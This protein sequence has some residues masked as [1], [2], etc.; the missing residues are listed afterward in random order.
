MAWADLSN[1]AQGILEY[2]VGPYSGRRNEIR[3]QFGQAPS[4]LPDRPRHLAAIVVDDGLID[5]ISRYLAA[6]TDEVYE[7]KDVSPSQIHL[8][9]AEASDLVLACRM[10]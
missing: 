7:V 1:D 3:L 5:E 10:P 6:E 8:K 9:M 2:L 4:I